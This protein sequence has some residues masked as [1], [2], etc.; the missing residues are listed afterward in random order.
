VRTQVS[1]TNVFVENHFPKEQLLEFLL[2]DGEVML[3]E[4]LVHDRA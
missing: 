3:S 1:V 4:L 2:Q